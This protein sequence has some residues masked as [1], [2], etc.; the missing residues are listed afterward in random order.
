MAESTSMMLCYHLYH[1]VLPGRLHS[2]LLIS[3]TNPKLCNCS[4]NWRY[5]LFFSACLY[6]LSH[7]RVAKERHAI[8]RQTTQ[9]QARERAT[10]TD[11]LRAAVRQ[12]RNE[13]PPQS[14]EER[15]AYFLE[16]VAMGEALAARGVCS[17]HIPWKKRAR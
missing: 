14:V 9:S 6:S 12:L 13:R 5:Y 4:A 2:L 3:M 7:G 10:Q 11:A 17:L 16:Q 15:E 1:R 8:A